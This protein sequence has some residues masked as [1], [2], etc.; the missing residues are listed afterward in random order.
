MSRDWSAMQG[1]M[2]AALRERQPGERPSQAA[3]RLGCAR[4]PGLW[5]TGLA[6]RQAALDGGADDAAAREAARAAAHGHVSP[7]EALEPWPATFGAFR[8]WR[9]LAVA[10]DRA[11]RLRYP[12]PRPG[13]S[14]RRARPSEGTRP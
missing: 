10:A 14:R 1:R 3:A 7:A 11:S 2:S 4:D 13:P 9:A 5:L 12:P 8:T 6:V